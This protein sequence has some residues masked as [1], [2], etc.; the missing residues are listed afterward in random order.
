MKSKT[1]KTSNFT[2]AKLTNF[3]KLQCLKYLRFDR[4]IE[5]ACTEGI[6]NADVNA[7]SPTSLIEVEIKISKTDFLSEFDGK[8]KIKAYKHRVLSGEIKPKRGYIVPNYFYFCT[9]NEL[10]D[11][12]LE[13]INTNYPKYGLLICDERRQFNRRSHIY[14]AKKAVKIHDNKPTNSAFE[15]IYKRL[16][17]EVITLKEKVL[18][19]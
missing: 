14:C 8:S 7:V 15:K 13:Y 5:L 6:N 9:T 18:K 3:I 11:F 17:S 19:I 16:S 4:Q 1:I 2:G 10:K 12:I